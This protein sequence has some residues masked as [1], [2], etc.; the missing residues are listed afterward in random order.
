MSSQS[1]RWVH[2]SFSWPTGGTTDQFEA[3]FK[4]SKDWLRYSRNCWLIYTALDEQVWRD[5]I[6]AVPGMDEQNIFLYEVD[7]TRAEGFLSEWIWK[8][9]HSKE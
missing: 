2:I 1:A 5:R 4:K 7:P 8:K 9:L 6:R 3:V